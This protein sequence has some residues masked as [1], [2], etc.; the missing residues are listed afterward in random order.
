MRPISIIIVVSALIFSGLVYFIVPKFLTHTPQQAEAPKPAGIDVLVAAHPL[1]A[2]TILKSDDLRWQRW[3][4]ESLDANYLVK[5][6]GAEPQRDAIGRAVLRGFANGEPITQFRLVKQGDSGYL[7]A[8]LTAGMRAVSVKIDPVSGDAGF[9]VPGDRVDV[10]LNEHY[11][12][13]Y[14]VPPDG[15]QFVETRATQKNVNSLVLEDVRILA[16]D[17]NVQDIDSKPKLG[18]TATLELDPTCAQKL[19]LAS[20]MGT[21]SLSLRSLVKPETVDKVSGLVQD[22]DVSLYLGRMEH[23]D[24]NAGGVRLW[25]GAQL[26]GAQR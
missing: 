1:P 18:V 24:S 2:G 10:L 13:T 20:Q 14:G 6:R 25:R 16:I 9:I 4:D 21:L 8:A 23:P 19:A 5:E 7:A 11:E 3:P 12:I 26:A 15:T 22:T 17:Q